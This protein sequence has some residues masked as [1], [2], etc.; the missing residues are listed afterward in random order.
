MEVRRDDIVGVGAGVCHC[1][2]LGVVDLEDIEF[3]AIDYGVSHSFSNSA[4][5]L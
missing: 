3:L 4:G 2:V 1:L 5:Q